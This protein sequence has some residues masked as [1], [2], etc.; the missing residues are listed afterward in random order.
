MNLPS[1]RVRAMPTISGCGLVLGHGTPYDFPCKDVIQYVDLATSDMQVVLHTL[2]TSAYLP[3]VTT[4]RLSSLIFTSG[5]TGV[6]KAVMIIPVD[7]LPLNRSGKL[8]RNVLASRE[9][10]EK[11]GTNLSLPHHV[12][13]D[14][15]NTERDVLTIFTQALN[16][17]ADTIDI[18][19]GLFNL[20]GHSLI[21]TLIVAALRHELKTSLSMTNFFKNPTVKDTAA[22]IDTKEGRP[23]EGSMS[24]A[25]TIG[26][27]ATITIRNE[28]SGPALFL[29]PETTSFASVYSSAFDH[30]PGK[31]VAFGDQTWGQDDTTK[32][33]TSIVTSLIPVM[34]AVQPQGPYFL[35]GWSFGGYLA[36]EAA[37]Q[38][39]AAGESVGI[40]MMFDSSVNHYERKIGKERWYSELDP[41]LGIID[42]GHWLTQFRKCNRMVYEYELRPGCFGGRVVLVKA[43]RGRGGEEH[44]PSADAYNS[45]RKILPQV[46]VIGIDSVHRAMF[47]QS[48]GPEMGK[49]ITGLLNEVEV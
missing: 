25:E 44:L 5:S 45:W 1:E 9:Y 29:F 33:I 20:G 3:S 15:T 18:H 12:S 24:I 32:S 49:I 11:Y 17:Q 42:K 28:L 34:R 43:L 48:N 19:E 38:L 13:G 27:S 26:A 10:F 40:V 41:L 39:E 6:P 35:S 37:L 4:S 7:E 2:T 23:S 8:D 31:I 22:Y 16:R 46:E 21:A 47:D 36:L 30:I 14:L